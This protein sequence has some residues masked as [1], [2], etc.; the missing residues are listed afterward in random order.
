MCPSNTLAK[1]GCLS[2]S[3]T[4]TSLNLLLSKTILSSL[5]I[6]SSVFK[7]TAPVPLSNLHTLISLFLESFDSVL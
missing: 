3:F 6:Y 5:E 2:P 1:I 4:I 7:I